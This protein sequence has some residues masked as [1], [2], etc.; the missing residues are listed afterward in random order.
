MFAA[1]RIERGRID[2]VQHAARD[3]VRRDVR[4]DRAQIQMLTANDDDGN[5][6]VIDENS[7][8]LLHINSP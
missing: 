2:L 6:T 1:Q 4:R 7:G 3:D 5:G 8:K